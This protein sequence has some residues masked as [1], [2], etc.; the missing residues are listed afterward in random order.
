ME[1]AEAED[2]PDPDQQAGHGRGESS[3]H[4]FDGVSAHLASIKD[5]LQ[6]Q[7]TV[8]SNDIHRNLAPGRCFIPMIQT[9]CHFPCRAGRQ[10]PNLTVI[11]TQSTGTAS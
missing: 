10:E 8:E 6:R 2:E 7:I 1:D 9:S 5:T 11:S 3:A 4:Q